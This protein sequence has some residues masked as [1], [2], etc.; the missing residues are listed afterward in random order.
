MTKHSPN[1]VH[2]SDFDIRN[3]RLYNNPTALRNLTLQ[4]ILSVKRLYGMTPRS[5]EV[6]ERLAHITAFE[7]DTR[8][9]HYFKFK[10]TTLYAMDE[11][12]HA[13]DADHIVEAAL[14]DFDALMMMKGRSIAPDVWSSSSKGVSSELG[15]VEQLGDW[16]STKELDEQVRALNT[17][18]LL[19]QVGIVLTHIHD[20][21]DAQINYSLRLVSSMDQRR[22]FSLLGIRKRA[23]A[24]LEGTDGSRFEII[25][26]SGFY[27]DETKL[28]VEEVEAL[29]V[30]M[31]IKERDRIKRKQLFRDYVGPIISEYVENADVRPEAR[32]LPVTSSYIVL[33]RFQSE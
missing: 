31:R 29:S 12:L 10:S 15:Y 19:A 16:D 13:D 4:A 6:G 3:Q 28:S 5:V 18:E 2:H 33:K 8:L 7:Q 22:G 1:Q 24:D 11:R 32:V 27:I 23:V 21:D 9:A 25:R 14:I 20:R 30:L 17:S 26:R